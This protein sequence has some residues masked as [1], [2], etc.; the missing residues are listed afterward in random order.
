MLKKYHHDDLLNFCAI[1]EA[2]K[3]DNART[4]GICFDD[5]LREVYA[6]NDLSAIS[7]TVVFVINAYLI[8]S[9]KVKASTKN[10]HLI[11]KHKLADI[12]AIHRIQT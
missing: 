6:T 1:H 3:A 2:Q 11:Y 5:K 9:P 12:Y 7:V 8:N 4:L 10:V